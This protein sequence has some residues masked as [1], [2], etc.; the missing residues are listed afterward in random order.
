MTLTDEQIVAILTDVFR[1]HGYEGASL[2]IIAKATGLARAS[3]YHRFPRGKAEMAEAVMKRAQAW[4]EV[5]ALAPLRDE[6]L[7]PRER[8]GAMAKHL[9]AFYQ[10]GQKSCLLDAM[11]IGE[12]GSSLCRLTKGAL[13]LWTRELAATV[14]TAGFG[15]AEARDRAE[16]ALALIQGTLVMARVREDPAPF[17]QVLDELPE[18]LLRT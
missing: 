13:D 5:E 15:P 7:S 11:S 3:L 17:R 6:S 8:I 16:R 4:L 2:Q 14:V 9:D 1:T 18:Q 10:S 12:P